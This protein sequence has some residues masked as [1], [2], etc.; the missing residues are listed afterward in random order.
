MRLAGS[1]ASGGFQ[2]GDDIDLDLVVEDHTKYA[3]YVLALLVS[4]PY[5]WRHRDREPPDEAW[6][7]LLPKLVCLNVIWET[8]QAQD[9]QRTDA[10]MGMEIALSRSLAGH[11]RF[12]HHLAN[13]QQLLAHFPQLVDHEPMADLDP[14]PSRTGRFLDGLL[15]VSGIRRLVDGVCYHGVRALHAL[16]RFARKRAP[17]ARE[18][19]ERM[20]ELKRPYAILDHPQEVD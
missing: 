14:E 20:K 1:L 4:L 19:V 6:T 3:T 2:E 10:A 11:A 7:P 18:H 5:A 16:I 13:N 12:R 17:Q 8:S 15:S 9:F